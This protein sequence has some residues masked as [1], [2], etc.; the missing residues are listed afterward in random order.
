M[1]VYILRIVANFYTSTVWVD[2][3][4]RDRRW[5][6]EKRAE[7]QPVF[8]IYSRAYAPFSSG[9]LT[10]VEMLQSG[11]YQSSREEF[12]SCKK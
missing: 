10:N 5:N 1:I 6:F 7:E 3:E 8:R 9:D 2:E 11:L 4:E 12:C